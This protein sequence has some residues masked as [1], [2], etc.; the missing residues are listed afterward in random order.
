M[1]E[2]EEFVEP[3][4]RDYAETQSDPSLRE[5]VRCTVATYRQH[6]RLAVGDPCPIINAYAVPAGTPVSVTLDSRPSLLIFGSYT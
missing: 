3:R 4:D 5:A 1:T 6:D 2:S